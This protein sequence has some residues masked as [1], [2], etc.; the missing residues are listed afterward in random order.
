MR[1]PIFIF[2]IILLILSISACQGELA[3]DENAIGG[4]PTRPEAT[5]IMPTTPLFAALHLADDTKEYGWLTHNHGKVESLVFSPD[6][7]ILATGHNS[8]DVVLWDMATGEQLHL[9]PHPQAQGSGLDLAF[10]SDGSLLAV[11]EQNAGRIMLWDIS[12]GE[13][14]RSLAAEPPLNNVTFSPDSSLLAA[15]K[16]SGQSQEPA[17][18][19][20]VWDTESWQQLYAFEDAAPPVIFRSDGKQLITRSGVDLVVWM[21]DQ[22]PAP[23]VYWDLE[24]G[25]RTSATQLDDYVM[26]MALS[27]DGALLALNVI[28]MG[29]DALLPATLILNLTNG[30]VRQ[31][32]PMPEGVEGPDTLAF[33]PDNSKLA[34]NYQPNRIII[35]DTVTGDLLRD[36]QGTAD[37]LQYPAFSP[38]GALL[39]AASSDGQI[40]FWKMLSS[41]LEPTPVTIQAEGETVVL[42]PGDNV[43]VDNYVMAQDPDFN[44]LADWRFINGWWEPLAPGV[45]V[46][47]DICQVEPTHPDCAGLLLPPIPTAMPGSPEELVVWH[48]SLNR[49]FFL[50]PADWYTATIAPSPIDGVQFSNAPT[51]QE[52]T[53]WVEFDVFP[54]PE[55]VSLTE[56]LAAGHGHVWA[57]EIT[58]EYEDIIEDIPADLPIVRQ[59]PENKDTETGES[60]VYQLIWVP[61][62]SK[63]NFL[64]WTA[65][66]GDQPEMLNLLERIVVGFEDY[67]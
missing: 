65:Y 67:E 16:S 4:S 31:A 49:F 47:I 33:S 32:L 14:L 8:G 58:E 48:D 27:P 41:S 5:E 23:L 57:G 29:P 34:V 1:R 12:S 52:A 40:L 44:A 2:L 38:D 59:R 24:S 17:G 53:Q 60:Y 30:A 36:L 63:K 10:N 25:Q 18:R 64:L 61:T 11:A 3:R 22:Q 43:T 66:P 39:A 35:W 62:K 13:M 45:T 20:F 9:F 56:W 42:I 55:D 54:N 19:T 50:Y 21:P 26:E 37:W 28:N 6:G 51:L 7:R 46:P 15:A